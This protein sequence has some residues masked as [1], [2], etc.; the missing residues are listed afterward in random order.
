MKFKLLTLIAVTPFFA[1]ATEIICSGLLSQGELIEI[2]I[3]YSSANKEIQIVDML[4]PIQVDN[5]FVIAWTN[6]A[7]GV[8]FVNILSRINGS[9]QVFINDQEGNQELRASMQ[10]IDVKNSLFI[11]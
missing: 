3:N 7:D 6:S 8:D 5:K 9:L 10:C 4:Y 2:E 1:S 11:N